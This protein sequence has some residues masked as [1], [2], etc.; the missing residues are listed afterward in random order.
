MVEQEQFLQEWAIAEKNFLRFLGVALIVIGALTVPMGV[1]RSPYQEVFIQF[2][3]II[4]SIIIM[5]SGALALIFSWR[6]GRVQRMIEDVAVQ[7]AGRTLVGAILIGILGL[8][9]ALDALR[10]GWGMALIGLV[11]LMTAGWGFY[12]AYRI[13]QFHQLHRKL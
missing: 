13:R 10:G 2:V 5:A 6:G 12:R 8:V 9:F 4:L 1:L 11:F 7:N 3:N